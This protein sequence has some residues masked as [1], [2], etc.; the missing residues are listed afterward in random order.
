MT[1]ANKANKRRQQG[2]AFTIEDKVRLFDLAE[3]NPALGIVDLGRRLAEPVKEGRGKELVVANPPPKNTIN[4][5]KRQKDKLRGQLAQKG[6]SSKRHR[7][8][9]YPQLEEALYV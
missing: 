2:Y 1:D 7:K 5:W 4:D 8:E 6:S 9:H 3:R